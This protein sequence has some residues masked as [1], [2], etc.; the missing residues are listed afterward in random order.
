MR[1]FFRPVL[2]LDAVGDCI[3]L[4]LYNSKT[5]FCQASYLAIQPVGHF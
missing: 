5:G 4:N 2:P 3:D 1:Q